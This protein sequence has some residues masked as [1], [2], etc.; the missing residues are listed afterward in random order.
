MEA[1]V[2]NLLQSSSFFTDNNKKI[3]SKSNKRFE[4]T[5]KSYG[6]D[7]KEN[8]FKSKYKET[9]G[10]EDEKIGKS[11][12][13][14]KDK[15]EVK[16]LGNQVED[17]EINYKD[18]YNLFFN[19][20]QN[21]KYNEN[22]KDIELEGNLKILDFQSLPEIDI[23]DL[24]NI[25]LNKDE[26]LEILSKM[27]LNEDELESQEILL[28][29]EN[30]EETLE[31]DLNYNLKSNENKL[32]EE[33]KESKVES[34][35][36]KTNENLKLDQ[37]LE[38]VSENGKAKL[39]N[40]EEGFKEENTEDS[41]KGNK[42]SVFEL[43]E[44][45]EGLKKEIGEEINPR[46]RF[47]L[48]F[49]TQE[50]KVTG[51][52]N[53][54]VEDQEPIDKKQF[55]EHIVEKVKYDLGNNKN[56]I[57]LTLKPESLGEMIMEVELVKNNLVAKVMVDNQKSKEIIENNLLQLK[58]GV[59]DTG[60]EIKSFEVF[61]GN[62]S[63]FDKQNSSGF[64]FNNPNKRNKKIKVKSEDQDKKIGTYEDNIKT[65]ENS[66]VSQYSQSN[67]NLFA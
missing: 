52:D 29:E 2:N 42:F 62:N 53:F 20:F 64:N 55:M 32:N 1:K 45:Q 49:E 5:L 3:E 14:L 26:I 56:Q 51:I 34:K 4:S 10:N 21:T 19:A 58:E 17:E 43:E 65:N 16:D 54:Q 15:K 47:D 63:D 67:L 40:I 37:N 18:K 28:N 60:L 9:V 13:K 61:V 30:I 24:E 36:L 59:K 31:K 46:D 8:S 33:S 6:G 22:I 66:I 7:S 39:L 50:T 27:D 41:N 44:I 57:K 25:S 12:D 11:Q 23:N 35:V 48:N 38:K